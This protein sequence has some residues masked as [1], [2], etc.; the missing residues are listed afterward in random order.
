MEAVSLWLEP[1][2]EPV[3]MKATQDAVT[4]RDATV[5]TAVE[6]L[7]SEGFV[8]R[9]AAARGAAAL[10]SLRP[11]RAATELP[12]NAAPSDLIGAAREE[13]ADDIFDGTPGA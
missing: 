11:Y 10:R 13:L 1:L 7:V 4:F 12:Q 6:L 3:S 5:S 8:E 2:S 9:K